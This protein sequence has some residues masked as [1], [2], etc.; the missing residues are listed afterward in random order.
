MS[1]S[2]VVGLAAAVASAQPAFEF[3]TGNPDG[4]MAVASRPE[5][6]GNIEI[7]AA[8]DFI[9]ASEVRL[10]AA[11]FVGLIPLEAGADTVESVTIEIYR[12]FPL[13]SDLT[14][15][16]RVP[17]RNNSPSDVAFAVREEV[18][19]FGVEILGDYFPAANSV[20]DGIHP[21]PQQNTQGDGPV[22]GRPVRITANL[23]DEIDLPPG[24]YFFVPQVKL[25]SGQFFWLSAPRPI[26]APGTPFVG[27]L[28]AWI[29]NGNLDPDWLR[30]GTDIVGGTP[31]P[32]FNMSFELL[33]K[34]ACY[35]NC[36][37]SSAAP[38]LNVN[39]FQCFLNAF[40][41]GAAYANCDESTAAPILNVNDFQCYV[42]K[43]AEG[44]A[45]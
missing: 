12:V 22:T 1:L 8:D 27:D 4:L 9:L 41:A 35:A 42:N 28:Q 11:K 24:H 20:L 43:Y 15:T 45:N 30:I 6:T 37:G 14:R 16:I 32:T 26:V 33:G 18:S 10:L 31:A 25:T 29:R 21:S 40:A 34:F 13:D 5:S 44:C 7:E 39:D 38:T 19:A 3:S 17:T 36:D 2:L 23:L